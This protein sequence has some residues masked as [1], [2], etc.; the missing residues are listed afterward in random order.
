MIKEREITQDI[1]C[2]KIPMA[3]IAVIARNRLSEALRM[4]IGLTAMDNSVDIFLTEKFKKDEST[5][6]QFEVIR[7]L[8]LH[9][10]STTPNSQFEYISP[11]MMADKLLEYEKILPY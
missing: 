10:Y 6:T 1:S 4:S 3:H 2:L 5:E 8:N 11:D 7:G 9:I